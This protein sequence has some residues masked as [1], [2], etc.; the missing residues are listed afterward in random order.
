MRSKALWIVKQ[1]GMWVILKGIRHLLVRSLSGTSAKTIVLKAT[2]QGHVALM[3]NVHG[4]LGLLLVGLA[5]S[6]EQTFS[7]WS[8]LN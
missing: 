5:V 3:S 6:D 7:L 4:T 2:S 8:N 1:I